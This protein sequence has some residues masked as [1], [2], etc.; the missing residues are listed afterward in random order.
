[1][2]LFNI[3][4]NK[5]CNFVSFCFVLSWKFIKRR[6]CCHDQLPPL[7]SSFGKVVTCIQVV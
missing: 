5:C 1:M 2:N 7:L 6:L 4:K 3:F